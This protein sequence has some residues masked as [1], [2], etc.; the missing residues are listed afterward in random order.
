[1][2][3]LECVTSAPVKEGIRAIIAGVEGVGKTTLAID[4]PRVL[5]V[6]LETGIPPGS[7]VNRVPQLE[8]Y[9]HVTQLFDEILETC[10]AGKF[11]YQTIVID[12]ATALEKLMHDATLKTDPIYIAGNKKGLIMDNALGGYGKAYNYSNDLMDAFLKKCDIL[13]KTYGV[14]IVMTCHVFA[15]ETMDPTAGKYNQWDLLLH[16]PKNN[17]AYG[18]REIVTQWADLVAF[19]HEPIMV[20]EGDK[21]SKGVS[22]NRGRILACSRTPSYVA[23]NRFGIA[24]E[25]ALPA[26]QGWNH[27]AK[28]IHDGTKGVVDVFNRD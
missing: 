21:M 5:L 25:I 12:S 13:A 1:M 6:P 15:S 8:L 19:L 9:A 2:A 27:L 17:K 7:S 4:A 16:S 23:K 14:N 20:I 3:I 11:P 26:V 28:A 22:A 24:T 10:K 18:K